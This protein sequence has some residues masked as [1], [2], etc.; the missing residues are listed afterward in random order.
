MRSFFFSRDMYGVAL[1]RARNLSFVF[2]ERPLTRVSKLSLLSILKP[3]NFSQV[4]FF[5]QRLSHWNF[6]WLIG[7]D[8][9]M[10]FNCISFCLIM[11]EPLKQ[12]F[13]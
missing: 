5:Y 13:R 11:R 7:A 2:L 1:A 8:N 6:F 3:N 10:T 9:E 12:I 4:L